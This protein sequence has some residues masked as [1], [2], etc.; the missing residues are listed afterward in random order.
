MA[1][2]L[3]NNNVNLPT[4][5]NITYSQQYASETISKISIHSFIDM[6]TLLETLIELLVSAIPAMHMSFVNCYCQ[7]TFSAQTS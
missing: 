5:T 1:S 3:K 7:Y 2:G 6:D 4:I